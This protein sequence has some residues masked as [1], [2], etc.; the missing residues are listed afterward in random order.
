MPLGPSAATGWAWLGQATNDE[1]GLRCNTYRQHAACHMHPRDQ[2]TCSSRR[3]ACNL[4]GSACFGAHGGVALGGARM[5]R[6]S[7]SQPQR[8][9][10]ARAIPKES[11]AQLHGIHRHTGSPPGP[12]HAQ[13]NRLAGGTAQRRNA[14]ACTTSRGTPLVRLCAAAVLRSAAVRDPHGGEEARQRQAPAAGQR[15]R[16]DAEQRLPQIDAAD[17]RPRMRCPHRLYRLASLRGAARLALQDAGLAPAP[18]RVP[19]AQAVPQCACCLPSIWC[20]ASCRI[21]WHR[22]IADRQAGDVRPII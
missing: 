7:H 17:A 3:A 14:P 18:S 22:Y 20:A 19:C 12:I 2:A 8:V 10:A 1:I 16:A 5:A 13:R 15:P 9:F 21:G 6:Q 4:R 11:A